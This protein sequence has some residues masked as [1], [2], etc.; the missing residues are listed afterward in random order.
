MY[1]LY[2]QISKSDFLDGHS[3]DDEKYLEVRVRM[4]MYMYV[5]MHR[6]CVRRY[7][8]IRM[9]MYVF[10][11]MDLHVSTHTVQKS[12]HTTSVTAQDF[13]IHIYMNAYILADYIYLFHDGFQAVY[14]A[15]CSSAFHIHNVPK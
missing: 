1:V 12:L 6:S 3:G 4:C 8:R 13:Y 5:F 10:A 11:H 15:V 14:A 2:A 7:V 9:Y